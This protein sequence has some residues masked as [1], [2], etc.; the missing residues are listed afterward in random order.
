MR[1]CARKPCGFLSEEVYRGF[2]PAL[3]SEYLSQKHQIQIG[4]EALRK[5]MREASLWRGQHRPA[6]EIHAWRPRRSSRGET[7]ED[8][9]LEGR[10][11]QLY[12]IHMDHRGD[13]LLLCAT[14]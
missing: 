14:G 1:S 4:R 10:G 13:Q 12:L 5:L 11:P 6:E 8:D 7:S 2:G 9:W 3:A